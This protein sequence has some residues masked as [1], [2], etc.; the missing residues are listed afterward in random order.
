MIKNITMAARSKIVNFDR[1]LENDSFLRFFR[2]MGF[3]Y[4]NALK[5]LEPLKNPG[6]VRELSRF[7]YKHLKEAFH[8]KLPAD[9]AGT[10]AE[11]RCPQQ[12][13]ADPR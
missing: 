10:R 11:S 6:G 8:A 2:T 7:L 4:F 13:D 9:V 3:D 12:S 1:L 5:N